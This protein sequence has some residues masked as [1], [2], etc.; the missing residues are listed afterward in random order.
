MILLSGTVNEIISFIEKTKEKPLS[1]LLCSRDLNLT[2]RIL[3]H[4]GH[5]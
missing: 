3:F 5:N 4:C 2:R 1:G